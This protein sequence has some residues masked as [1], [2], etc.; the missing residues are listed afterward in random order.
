M[1]ISALLPSSC[2]SSHILRG[3]WSVASGSVQHMIRSVRISRPGLPLS[4]KVPLSGKVFIEMAS[5]TCALA[6]SQRWYASY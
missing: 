6:P 3:T 1:Y 2:G 5:P 4:I